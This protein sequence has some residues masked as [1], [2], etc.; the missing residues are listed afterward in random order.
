[1][2]ENGRVSI[3]ELISEVP[4]VLPILPL[5]KVVLFPTM[6][7]PIAVEKEHY[8][9]LIEDALNKDKLIGV[10][11]SKVL[12]NP[13]PNDIEEY[14]TMASIIRMIKVPDG[15]IRVLAQ[16]LR[17]IK[18]KDIVQ[19]KPYIS[20][21]VEK[22]EEKPVN[23]EE[24]E[25]IKNRLLN[26]F[27]EFVEY[28]PY[29]PEEIVT[30]AL[31]IEDTSNLV[32]FI[33]GNLKIDIS[34]RQDLLET[35][36]VKERCEKLIKIL[37]E[38]LARAKIQG[39]IS[40]RV[41]K[42]L[43]ESQRKAILREQL[44][45]IKKELGEEDPLAVQIKEYKERIKKAKMTKEAEETALSELNRLEMVPPHSPEYNVIRNYLDWLCDLP[46]QKKTKDNTDIKKAEKI[47]DEDHHN[48]QDVKERI[49][50]FLSVR[51]LKK[52]TKG[53]IICLVGP[54]GVGKTSIGQSIAR[55]MGRKFTRLSL[56]GVHDEAEIRGHRR[57]YIG[58][59]PGRI[60]QHLKRLKTKNP[61]F[62]L[63]EIDK[64]GKDFRGDPASAL[65]EVLDPE[66]NTNFRDNFLEVAFDLSSVMFI[67]TANITDTIPP[68]LLDR[69]E[70]IRMPGYTAFDKFKI[71]TK[72]LIPRM[73]K[74][75]GL[76][77]KQI[78]FTEEAIKK[79]INNYTREA[80]VR[81]LEREIGK[82]C[83]KVARKVAKGEGTFFKITEDSLEEY[84]GPIKFRGEE[85]E[86]EPSIGV[87]TGLAWTPAGGTIHFVEATIM[88]GK[89]E[90]IL[91]GQLG[92]VLKESARAALSYIKSN[93]S[94][95]NIDYNK[96]VNKDIHIHIPEGAIP[97][98]GPSAG[99]TLTVALIS[100]FTE[101]P[102]SPDYGMTGEITLRG[103]VL[104]IGGVKEKVLAAKMAGIKNI[105]LPKDNEKDL[106]E[107][108]E[109]Y[110]EG[111]SFH[112]VERIEEAVELAIIG[113]KIEKK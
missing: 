93:A 19:E 99:I 64:I 102:V 76:K 109:E 111:L 103:R 10:F 67:T 68:P 78:E 94:L 34:A 105:I 43:T 40:G 113:L 70:I 62:M 97:K 31:N 33:S 49:I 54:P 75:N 38:T 91:T 86:K 2:E 5:R 36:D 81:N 12:E 88:D 100:L 71:A 25:P 87:A 101:K 90:L 29:L 104:P 98:D 46:W 26:I 96:F 55:A 7:L 110:K 50:E 73:I 6:V 32:D 44:K 95:F 57:T 83:R 42:E 8:I 20:A 47:L 58:A 9:K 16:G 48:L 15:S 35:L 39:E 92:D 53:P 14:G 27:K 84:L 63:D 66:Q 85:K 4:T 89:G 17:R 11:L 21:R 82:V 69:M 52:D 22:V 65:L 59:L 61:I 74:E 72:Y 60:I 106:V 37:S 79:I 77:K 56:G 1:M 51:K 24:I 108:P 112:F 41:Q 18:I 30:V 13:T 45:E 107:I 80:G 23:E 3:E 28:S